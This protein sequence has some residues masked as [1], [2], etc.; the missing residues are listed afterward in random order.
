MD[1]GAQTR[2]QPRATDSSNSESSPEVGASTSPPHPQRVHPKEGEAA[3]HTPGPWV[4]DGNNLQPRHRDPATQHVHTILDQ[5][6]GGFG[7]TGGKLRDLLAEQDAN[8]RLIAAAPLLLAV[9]QRL[10]ESA[11]YWSEY[12]V[13]LGI[14]ADLQ[15]AIASATVA[16]P[17]EA[18]A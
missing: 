7:Y 13:P 5:G 6:D 8:L 4:W 1:G 15:A 14:V 12:D 11:D 2:A 18:A 17:T 9:C 3:A 16:A 10:A